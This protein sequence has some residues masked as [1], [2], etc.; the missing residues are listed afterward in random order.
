MGKRFAQ[1]LDICGYKNSSNYRC[2]Q[3]K[4]QW[5]TNSHPP[6]WLEG[7]GMKLHPLDEDVEQ[8]EL[9]HCS[10]EWTSTTMLDNCSVLFPKPNTHIS[11]DPVI[12]FQVF[13]KEMCVYI[14]SKGHE[15]HNSII[16]NSI[17]LDTTLMSTNSRI[18]KLW[19]IHTIGYYKENKKTWNSIEESHKNNDEQNSNIRAYTIWFHLY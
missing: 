7:K 18:D 19:Y 12:L 14:C 13:N 4:T 11:Y 8:L 10:W 2:S 17:I 16:Y 1:G 5:G 6:E 9:T 15:P 3:I